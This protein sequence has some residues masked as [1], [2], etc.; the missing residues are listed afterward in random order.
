MAFP[1]TYNFNYYKGDT[2]EFKIYPKTTNGSPFDLT[3]YTVDFNIAES[4]GVTSENQ[5]N[6]YSYIP[7]DGSFVSCAIIPS[8]GNLL[9]AGT[10]YVYDV[11]IRKMNNSPY[12][13][14]H[15]LLTG[16]ITVTDQVTN[17]TTPTITIPEAPTDLL[18]AEIAPG[19]IGASWTPPTGGDAPTG[20]KIYGKAPAIPGA[21][22][23][24][25]ITT[26]TGTTYS[27]SSVFGQPLIPGVQ[28]FVKVTSINTA[29][30]STGFVESS[31]TIA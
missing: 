10:N 21:T 4:R 11:E 3:G 13:L 5:V 22:D 9:E 18:L 24:L 20:Y 1:G 7:V 26:V 12:P 28:Y 17:I 19:T 2:L 29:G 8:D 6:A 15:T 31:V 16:N 25:E 23:Y 30:E 14:V 27:A